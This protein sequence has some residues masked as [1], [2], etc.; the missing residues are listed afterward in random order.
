MAILIGAFL[1][2]LIGEPNNPYHPVRIIGWFAKL[3]EKIGFKIM[4][5]HLKLAE[6]LVVIITA[7][8]SFAWCFLLFSWLIVIIKF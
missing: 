3:Q 4:K 2:W 5:N 1:D 6:A 8:A 7:K